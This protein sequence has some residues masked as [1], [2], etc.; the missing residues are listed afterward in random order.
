MYYTTFYSPADGPYVETYLSVAGN[1][2]KLVKQE[3][4]KY[5]GSIAITIIF[6]QQE[7]IVNFAKYEVLSPE[8][9]DTTDINFNFL[10]Q[11]RYPLANGKYDMEIIISDQNRDIKPY[12]TT[13]PLAIDFPPGQ[14]SI[15]GI[16]L[17]ESI[18]KT[19]APNILTK[20][21]Y[22]IIPQV[23][24]FYP[25]SAGTMKFYAE[26]YN[27]DKHFGADSKFL[28]KY[29]IESFET[30]QQLSKFIR[31]RRES[32]NEVVAILGEFDISSLPSGNYNLILEVRDHENKLVTQNQLFFQ[33]SNPEIEYDLSDLAAISLDNTFAGKYTSRDT[34]AQYIRFLTPIST[35]IERLF[36]DRQLDEAG[37]EN[38]QRFFLNFWRT[39]DNGNPEKAWESYLT[40]VEKVNELYKTPNTQGYRTDRGQIYLKYGPPN[41]ISE[42]YNEPAA[43]PYEIW[44]YYVLN[45]NQRNKKFVFYT[46]DIVTNNFRLVHSDAIGEPSN[47]R[48]QVQIHRRTYDPD[49]IDI[50]RY[51]DTWGSKVNDYYDNPH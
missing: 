48:W 45:N 31:A 33:R 38:M 5:R 7:E 36:I 13:Q 25:E 22:D 12:I 1:S 30:R 28:L 17:V 40:Q 26:I 19:E 46:E 34:L 20:G 24:D 16:E 39:R 11:Q 42:S 44:Q 2:I 8:V 43:Y 21:G 6:R 9:A 51:P 50:G 47:Y 29:Y 4:G 10:D 32:T 23:M 41:I 15:S 14:L 3:N 18:K 37:L 27:S 49:N 35:E